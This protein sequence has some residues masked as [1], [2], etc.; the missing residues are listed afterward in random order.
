[1]GRRVRFTNQIDQLYFTHN[2]FVRFPRPCDNPNVTFFFILRH[3]FYMRRQKGL[4][5]LQLQ[6]KFCFWP[7]FWRKN[8]IAGQNDCAKATFRIKHVILDQVSFLICTLQQHSCLIDQL[9]HH[10]II[11]L[12]NI[13]NTWFY[14]I[15]C[16]ARIDT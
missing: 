12:Y 3:S 4:L 6:K 2:T 10:I 9:V 15:H 11:Q 1:M 5:L 14:V 7:W 8:N 13:S 16:Q